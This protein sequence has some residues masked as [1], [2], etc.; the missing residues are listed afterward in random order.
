[1]RPTAG[2]RG[3]FLTR[4]NNGQFLVVC[5]SSHGLVSELHR[6]CGNID[7]AELFGKRFDHDANVV[8]LPGKESLA[9]GGAGELEPTGTQIGDGRQ[10]G[11]V[12]LLLGDRLDTAQQAMLARLGQGDRRAFAPGPAGAADAMDVRPRE[13]TERRS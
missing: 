9:Q 1:M 5:I 13:R 6:R 4:R 12:D 8:Q 11:D 7:D 3:T 10:S 2:A